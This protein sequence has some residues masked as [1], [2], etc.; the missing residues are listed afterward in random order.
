[1]NDDILIRTLDVSTLTEA[2]IKTEF[3]HAMKP[4]EQRDLRSKIFVSYLASKSQ[5]VLRVKKISC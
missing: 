2:N 5:N 3:D 4:F 1:M